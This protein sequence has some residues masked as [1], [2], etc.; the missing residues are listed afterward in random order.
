VAG[1]VFDD[2]EVAGDEVVEFFEVVDG[3]RLR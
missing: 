3:G 1:E 2:G